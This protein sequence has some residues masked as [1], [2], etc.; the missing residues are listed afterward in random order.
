MPP[1]STESADDFLPVG[2]SA[3]LVGVSADTLKRWEGDGRIKSVRT[4]TGH[5]RYRR[6]D[7]LAL[8]TDDEPAS[9]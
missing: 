2:A 3:A 5:R 1:D 6:S 9:A 7:V 8:L 4:P